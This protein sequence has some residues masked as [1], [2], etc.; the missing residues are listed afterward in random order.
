MSKNGKISERVAG[1]IRRLIADGELSDGAELGSEAQLIKRFAASRPSIREAVRILESEG[2]VSIVKGARTVRVQQPSETLPTRFIALVLR[3][4]KTSLADAYR[5]RTLLEPPAVREVVNRG[6]PKALGFLQDIV[7]REHRAIG[8]PIAFSRL[9]VQ[10]HEEITRLSGNK[11]THLLLTMLRSIFEGHFEASVSSASTAN[12][13]L[14]V[15]AHRILL[16]YIARKD[17]NGAEKFWARHLAEVEKRMSE[18]PGFND[19]VDMF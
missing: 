2:L 7:E 16:R 14:A 8:D 6:D 3:S 17:S 5:A 12:F 11:T 4:Q 19:I 10:F 9:T 15:K 13:N 18:F 1:E